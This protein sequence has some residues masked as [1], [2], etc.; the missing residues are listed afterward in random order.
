[1]G[2]IKEKTKKERQKDSSKLVSWQCLG[3]VA[4]C[5]QR[6]WQTNSCWNGLT[7]RSGDRTEHLSGVH[8]INSFDILRQRALLIQSGDIGPTGKLPCRWNCSW[9]VAKPKMKAARALCCSGWRDKTAKGPVSSRCEILFFDRWLLLF[10]CLSQ[11]IRGFLYS[12][13]QFSNCGSRTPTHI[14]R[15]DAVRQIVYSSNLQ[16]HHVEQL[17]TNHRLTDFFNVTLSI[18]STISQK[19]TYINQVEFCLCRSQTCDSKISF[20]FFPLFS[21]PSS[22]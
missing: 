16:Q 10:C 22:P 9:R 21:F 12:R 13:N 2:R 11:G 6:K 5:R 17:P 8:P 3:L 20:L 14:L 19:P 7:W 4:S 15:G 1:M 18:D